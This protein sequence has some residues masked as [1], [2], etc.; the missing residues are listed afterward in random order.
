M[1]LLSFLF[2]FL[3]LML[4]HFLKELQEIDVHVLEEINH[5]RFTSLD[6]F[7]IFITN[8]A[9][10]VT[11]SFSIFLLVYAYAKRR[12]V[13]ERKG[14]LLLI[15]LTLNSAIADIIKDLVE[16]PR[17]FVTY[18]YVH[19]L[20]VVHSSSFPSGHT[21]EVSL[22]A[23]AVSILFPKGGWGIIVAW[24]WAILVAYSRMD[25]GVHYPSDILG[26]FVISSIVSFSFIKLMI[27]LDFFKK[28]TGNV[29]PGQ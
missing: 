16:R 14:W 5:D 27:H 8:A 7:F 4:T 24:I 19:N 10:V 26:S 22:L 18:R 23:F 11:Y 13:L 25:L 17:P 21:A 15:A 28:S 29:I 6:A 3:F 9:T 20:V 2:Q 12:F 1:H